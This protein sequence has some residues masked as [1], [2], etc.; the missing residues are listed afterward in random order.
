[1][2]FYVFAIAFL[3]TKHIL[4]RL[5][6]GIDNDTALTVKSVLIFVDRHQLLLTMPALDNFVVHFCCVRLGTLFLLS[7]FALAGHL[8]LA[9]GLVTH[10]HISVNGVLFLLSKQT[11]VVFCKV[12]LLAM[13]YLTTHDET[14]A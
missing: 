14:G 9:L 3:R 12:S 7:F 2:I 6:V 11:C 13:A 1:M 5:V 4:N 8:A 10:V